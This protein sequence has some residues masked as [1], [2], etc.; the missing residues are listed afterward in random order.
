[1]GCSH[2]PISEGQRGRRRLSRPSTHIERTPPPNPPP[3]RGRAFRAVSPICDSPAASGQRAASPRNAF[4]SV[5]SAWIPAFASM[6]GGCVTVGGPASCASAAQRKMN[7]SRHIPN[8]PIRAFRRLPL[9]VARR[10]RI[11][12]HIRWQPTY[13]QT[14]APGHIR[15][16]PTNVKGTQNKDISL[17]PRLPPEDAL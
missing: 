5:H 2:R 12:G 4:A 14:Y 9:A 1:M 6:T 10:G 13:A 3:S 17:M 16:H 8:S 15:L 11:P 7:M